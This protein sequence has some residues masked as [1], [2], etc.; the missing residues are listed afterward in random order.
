MSEP[1]PELCVHHENGLA[2]SQSW[3]TRRV[4]GSTSPSA[5]NSSTFEKLFKLRLS[6]GRQQEVVE[7]A[8]GL[9]LVC[10]GDVATVGDYLVQELALAAFARRDLFAELPIQTAR[11]GLDFAEVRKQLARSSG[12]LLEPG[13]QLC[14]E[15]EKLLWC[16]LSRA[17]LS[18]VE[19]V[20]PVQL[21]QLDTPG[22]V[23]PAS[24]TG[25]LTCRTGRR[26]SRR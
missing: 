1:T 3:W 9:T 6:C 7:G 26:W 10:L 24:G 25:L 17:C 23:Q 20:G 5:S 11:V 15:Q 8:E 16:F 13:Y 18:G 2:S 4:R 21:V 19:R 22:T 12:E 14:S